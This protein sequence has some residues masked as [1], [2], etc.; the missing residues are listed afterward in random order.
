MTS[1]RDESSIL[2]A[3]KNVADF[4]KELPS[5]I[6]ADEIIFLRGSSS[7]IQP[8]IIDDAMRRIDG[9]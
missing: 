7:G 1:L 9:G 6:S 4:F 3:E 2:L 5:G 8:T